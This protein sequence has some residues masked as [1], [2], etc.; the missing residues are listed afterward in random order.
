MNAG[1][2]T[3]ANDGSSWADAFQGADGLQA[4]L[5]VALSGDD[6]F[7]TE[8]VYRASS[9]GTRTES[10]ALKNGVTLWGGFKGGESSPDDR[11]L[12]GVGQS[13]LS[14]DLAGDDSAGG[15]DDNSYHLI[16]TVGTDA[17]AVIDRF[18]IKAGNANGSGG[19]NDRGGG[20]LCLGNVSPTVRDCYFVDNRSSF[21][22]AAGYCNSGAAPTFTDC[23]FEGG[24][25][26]SFGGAF[27]L[28]S[29]GP[30]RFERC[31]F[32]NNTA[33]RA[34]ALEIFA[35]NGVIVSNCIFANNTATGSGGGGAIWVGSGGDTK[36]RNCTIFENYST[37]N[38][39]AG[40]RNQNA[41]Q[42][43]VVNCILWG[44]QG[45][46]GTQAANNQANAANQISY[47]IVEGG[48]TGVGNLNADPLIGPGP[49]LIFLP[50]TGSPCI[51]AG[52]NSEVPPG[53]TTEF[54]GG[55]RFFDDPSSADTGLGTA[56]IVDIGAHELGT[57]NEVIPGCSSSFLNLSKGYAPAH[58]GESLILNAVSMQLG[59]PDLAVFFAGVNGTSAAGCGLLLPGLGEVLLDPFLPITFLGSAASEF[60]YAYLVLEV[61]DKPALVGKVI[62]FQAAGVT[63]S[64]TGT[65]V[66]FSKMLLATIYP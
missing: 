15:F 42:T 52:N 62:A 36:F 45:P 18:T 33:A 49:F 14:G 23:G 38:A 22:G 10:F 37:T 27:D 39:V 8:G 53:S 50:S 31:L 13:I 4:A 56:P 21:G 47:S 3:G 17:S 24:Q 64:S 40:L 54:W 48:F 28:A 20:I 29:A 9:T 26:G 55:P 35:T 32:Y 43:T 19:N 1:L 2:S 12:L 5:A 66:E 60:G 41:P 61:P 59:G 7:V 16:R 63:L 34:G 65:T 25:G 44:N 57:W 51:D 11:P 46:G 6:I 30:V 58:I